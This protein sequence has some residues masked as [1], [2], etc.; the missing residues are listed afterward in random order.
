MFTEIARALG[1]PIWAAA[2]ALV[3]AVTAAIAD[4]RSGKLPNRLTYPALIAALAA[5]AL[6]GGWSG[7][8]VGPGLEWSL[9]GLAAGL[10]PL[11]LCWLAGGIGGGD[12]KLMGAF[13]AWGGWP[14]AV[15]VVMYGAIIGGVMALVVMIRK[16]MVRRTLRRIFIAVAL[17]VA[18]GPAKPASPTDEDSPRIPFAVALC[19][20]AVAAGAVDVIR[21]ALD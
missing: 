7:G 3:L 4:G 2:A 21:A 18:P 1:M 10:A 6:V 12:V 13:G 8:A 14:F 5:H 16:K 11:G 15:A 19:C 17:V 9:L 20:G